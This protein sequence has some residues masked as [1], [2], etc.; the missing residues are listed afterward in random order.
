MVA[1]LQLTRFLNGLIPNVLGLIAMQGFIKE[2]CYD[3]VKGED[4]FI[5]EYFHIL[6]GSSRNRG[7]SCWGVENRRPLNKNA[8]HDNMY[9]ACGPSMRLKMK[10]E[11]SFFDRILSSGKDEIS[12]TEI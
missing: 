1:G 4:K 3:E 7:Q 5:G 2:W 8:K 9:K 11:N 10:L 6:R 12:D